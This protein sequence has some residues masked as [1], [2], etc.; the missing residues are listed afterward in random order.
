MRL[1]ERHDIVRASFVPLRIL[2]LA[3]IGG[4]TNNLPIGSDVGGGSP[5]TGGMSGTGGSG[6]TGG[7]GSTGSA[8]STGSVSSTAG[9]GGSGG[10][11]GAPC[12]P[13]DDGN[14]CTDDVCVNG[15]PGSR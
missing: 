14:P 5:G 15:L 7:W 13:A 11:G 6:G 4:C 3:L 2:L 9:T 12:V 8:S 1:V 10:V